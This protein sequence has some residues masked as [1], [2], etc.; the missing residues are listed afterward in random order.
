[1]YNNIK[2][3]VTTCQQSLLKETWVNWYKLFV[4]FWMEWSL[5]CDSSITLWI[6]WKFYHL[7]ES[8]NHI[9]YEA[10]NQHHNNCTHD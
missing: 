9:L 8:I 10:N 2:R 7:I 4:V 3:K 6:K 1:M 5:L